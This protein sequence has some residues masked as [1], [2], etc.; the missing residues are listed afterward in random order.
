MCAV[1]ASVHSWICAIDKL[2][3]RLDHNLTLT[4]ICHPKWYGCKT[5]RSLH[6]MTNHAVGCNHL[7]QAAACLKPMSYTSTPGE[8]EICLTS[9]SIE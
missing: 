1:D 9:G 2:A 4:D 3:D 6:T 5:Y 7:E 8:L